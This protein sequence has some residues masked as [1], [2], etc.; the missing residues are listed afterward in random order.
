MRMLSESANRPKIARRSTMSI[1]CLLPSAR[2]SVV[3]AR[4]AA[5]VIAASRG[6]ERRII[7]AGP[8]AEQAGRLDQQHQGHEPEPHAIGEKREPDATEGA[9]DA[10]QDRGDKS[11]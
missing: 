3:T 11:T 8:P 6:P 10:D 1:N 9:C 4:Q 7:S 5:A 2:Q